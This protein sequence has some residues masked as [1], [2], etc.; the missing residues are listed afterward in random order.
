M[1]LEI[2]RNSKY[3]K[4]TIFLAYTQVN[5][6]QDSD[7]WPPFPP[8]PH[9][10]WINS[11]NAQYRTNNHFAWKR[12]ILTTVISLIC[13]SGVDNGPLNQTI[14]MGSFVLGFFGGFFVLFFIC[15]G[16]ARGIYP[17]PPWWLHC[18]W[19][20]H[21]ISPVPVMQP[22]RMRIHGI[23]TSAMNWEC[24][25][26]STHLMGKLYMELS[27]VMLYYKLVFVHALS[28]CVE[29]L[30]ISRIWVQIKRMLL[31]CQ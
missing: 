8:P 25:K 15:C 26:Y 22:R 18:H 14:N 7:P 23:Y 19:D 1:N 21:T 13:G 3:R 10:K 27:S 30:L 31:N 20:D 4:H 6:F 29:Y 5:L 28:F 24:K 2:P 16:L 12:R 11:I 9:N 17:F